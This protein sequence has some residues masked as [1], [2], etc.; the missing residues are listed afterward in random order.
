MGEQTIATKQNIFNA[1]NSDWNVV[2]VASSS[3][4]LPTHYSSINLK[5]NRKY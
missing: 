5:S 3:A 1:V 4:T 2:N